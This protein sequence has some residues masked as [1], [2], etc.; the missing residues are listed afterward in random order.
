M[1][2]Q[3]L[4]FQS[5]ATGL[6]RNMKLNKL[7][8]MWAC[9]A[10]TTSR[11]Y[12]A[13]ARISCRGLSGK[14]PSILGQRYRHSHLSSQLNRIS[15]P[16]KHILALDF[17]GVLCAS[18]KESSQ[19]AVQAAVSVWPDILP[20]SSLSPSSTM[21]HLLCKALMEVR[22][23]IETGYENVLLAR[24]FY[25]QL[26]E[27]DKTELAC[28]GHI[29]QH[30]TPEFRD[31]LLHKYLS[32]KQQ[33]SQAFAGARDNQITTNLSLWV[34][35]NAIYPHISQ[36]LRHK[37]I[38]QSRT[39]IITTKQERFVEAILDNNGINLL[40]RNNERIA[41][42]N[43]DPRCSKVPLALRSNVFDLENVFGSKANV[44]KHL[45]EENFQ[46]PEVVIH[47]VEDRFE[48]LLNIAK[49][50]DTKE[51]YSSLRRVQLYLVDWGYNTED[52]RRQLAKSNSHANSISESGEVDSNN[53]HDIKLI[54]SDEFR[55]LVSNFFT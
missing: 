23:I 9:I 37:H 12:S 42:L 39:F 8:L 26:Q 10:I 27:T 49:L 47:F 45:L 2:L 31:D 6:C 51:E 5:K 46:D 28:V 40:K 52:Q 15:L 14:S 38:D 34:E 22:P 53:K 18:S 41:I 20:A 33:L 55:Q 24:Y 17:D 43:S 36:L 11:Y 3:A 32:N 13:T 54:G 50:R 30:W 29:L 19:T 1:L 35:R 25:E 4:H 44:L 16:P 48:T 21:H 7:G